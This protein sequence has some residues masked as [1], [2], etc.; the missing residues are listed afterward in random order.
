MK[1]LLNLAVILIYLYNLFAKQNFDKSL[2]SF[3]A[4]TLTPRLLLS[5][6]VFKTT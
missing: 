5:N 6:V 2:S 4:Q 1:Q 3:Y